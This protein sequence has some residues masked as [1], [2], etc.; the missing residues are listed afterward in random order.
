MR[1][2]LKA[3]AGITLNGS[4]VS[5][6]KDQSSYGISATQGTA[7]A[8]PVFK[9]SAINGRPALQFDGAGDFLSMNLPVN[10]LAGMTIIAVSSTSAD[11]SGT[12]VGSQYPALFWNETASWGTVYLAPF[13][14]NVQF[15][16][17]T[18]E[19]GNMPVYIRPSSIGSAVSITTAIKNGATESLFVNGALALSV[20][21]QFTTLKNNSDTAYLGRG[22]TGYFA[23]HI[24]EVLIYTKALT[25]AERNQAEGYLRAK[26]FQG[27]LTNSAPSV[28]AGPDRTVTLPSTVSLSG[29][30]SDDGEPNGTLTLAWSK[31]SG[32]GTV[33]F[34]NPASASTT[35]AVSA[36]GTYV[37]R[38]TGNDGA[39]SASS[40]VIV[41]ASTTSSA[42]PPEYSISGIP[43]PPGA[44]IQALVNANPEGTSFVIK[45]GV[46]RMQMVRPK[47]GNRFTGEP[48]AVMNGSR[49]L[50]GF[51]R[52][53][54]YWVAYNQTQQGP[55]HGRCKPGFE[56]CNRPEDLFINDVM[57]RH[58]TSLGG[59]QPGRWFFD[60]DAN[61]IYMADDPSGKRVE[62]S[63]SLYAFK[64][65]ASNVTIRGLVIEKYAQP[66]QNGAIF[67]R[68]GGIM[69]TAWLI[70]NNEVRLNHGVGIAGLGNRTIVRNN[71]VHKN[72]QMGIGGNGDDV[73]VE[74]NEIYENLLP[75]VGVDEIWEGGATKFALTNRLIVRNNSVHHNYASGLWTDIDNMN[76]LYEGNQVFDNLGNGIS[77]EISYDAVI[78]NNVLRNNGK[79]KPSWLWGSQILIQNS[80]RVEVYGNTVEVAG[81]T[82]NGISI[83][84]QNRGSGKYGPYIPQGNYIHH[85]K[86]IFRRSP[87]GC[88]GAVAE[89]AADVVYSSGGNRFDFNTYYVTDL[90][91]SHWR[92]NGYKNWN[93]LRT[94]GH[95]RN[96]T[97]TTQAP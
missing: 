66:P 95:E 87:Q 10:G 30:A 42:P 94:A 1:L 41:T 5:G 64:G 12:W 23:G 49:L 38:L 48:G 27:G 90:N 75:V 76:T 67:V 58:A 21:G 57:L 81:D 39:L 60:Y 13:Q 33:T 36:A 52:E 7:G 4:G 46:H 68:D 14:S 29:T 71:K 19:S 47:N 25:D 6:W 56:R 24:A 85:N 69:G 35:A 70:E 51:V 31:V 8:Q 80:L 78:R 72:G 62:T 15:R 74:G 82:G 61:K 65:T 53:G 32:P 73:L 40:D 45:A 2:W 26:Y 54:S 96:G 50:T 11:R 22:T 37:L 59:V 18:S 77:H 34:T 3:D 89:Y 55:V 88:S 16:F 93:T 83:I 43:V 91:A 92:W 9:A 63:V 28:D 20:G 44:D 97:L 79:N 17:G 84:S 86:I